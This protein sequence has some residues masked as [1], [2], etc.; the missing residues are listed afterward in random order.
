[1]ASNLAE[2]V[3]AALKGLSLNQKIIGGVILLAVLGGLASLTFFE[4]KA[5]YDVLFSNLTQEDAA[6]V[7]GKLKEQRV[8]YELTGNGTTIMVPEALVYET[9]LNLA[10]QGLPRGGGVG[11]EIFDKTN[12]GTT[13][14]VQ[15]LNYQRALQGELART[16]REFD[17][18]EEARVHI[19]TPKESVFVEDQKPTTASVSVRLRGRET[20]SKMQIQSIVNLV[21]SAVPGLTPENITVVDTAGNL[22]YHKDGNPDTIMTSDQLD[23]ELAI[24]ETLRKKIEGLLAGAV[25]AEHVRARV[26][27]E[28]DFDRV[29]RTE[30]NYD[31]DGK[32][33]RSE[34]VITEKDTRGSNGAEGVPGAKGE[35]E[36]ASAGTATATGAGAGADAGQGG[37]GAVGNSS[38]RNNMTRNYEI[39]RVTKQVQQAT[40]TIKRLSV[41]VMVDGTYQK[42]VD[43]NGKTSLEYRP[44][45]AEEMQRFDKM[46]KNCIGYNQDRGD[47]VEVT[48]I[49][50]AKPATADTETNSLDQWR[51]LI[52]RLAM[53]LIYLLL[54]IVVLLFV[55]RPF[56]RL[57]TAKQLEARRTAEAAAG[58]EITLGEREDDLSFSPR[59]MTDQERIYKLAQSDPSRAADLVR[60]WLR[61]E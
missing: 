55:V 27:A 52:E 15:R 18:V 43:K 36:A 45:P 29:N 51:D 34:Q 38:S 44:L 8:P 7:L 54:A 6:A 35:M 16:I 24:E 4:K 31:P 46:V 3:L 9:R 48:N 1:M 41:A 19:A 21:A 10:G 42:V 39:S 2:Q 14:F 37:Q 23:Y 57:M 12:F 28:L 25:G 30:E 32:V 33:V 20:L 61:E 13:D 50:F 17:E 58:S 5:T 56:F 11:F 53:P 60:R 59:G 40:G 49:S 47:Q 22:L 26:T